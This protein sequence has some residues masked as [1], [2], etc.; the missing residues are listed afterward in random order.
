[1]SE[2]K[3][4]IGQLRRANRRAQ[5]TAAQ[6]DAIRAQGALQYQWLTTAQFARTANVTVDT[7]RRWIHN[8]VIQGRFVGRNYLI[9]SDMVDFAIRLIGLERTRR[10]FVVDGAVTIKVRTIVSAATM[11]D[12]LEQVANR[13]TVPL[14]GQC[15]EVV[16]NG[17]S[18][19]KMWCPTNGLAGRLK[20]GK[21]KV[22]EKS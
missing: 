19:R 15:R 18:M 1:M 22:R 9:R 7:V 11:E 6:A 13:G 17:A 20:I 14:C 5:L 10:T 12:A 8:G 16:E 3:I 4:N 2:Q 21:V